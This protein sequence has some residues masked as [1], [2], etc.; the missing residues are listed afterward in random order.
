MSEATTPSD[1]NTV[2][3]WEL[4][5]TDLEEAK[6]FYGSVFGW[7]FQSFGDGFEMAA[8][9]D[10]TPLGGLDSATGKG[11]SPAGR[12]ARIY[13]KVSD[14]EQTLK[15]VASNGGAVEQSRTLISPEYGWWALFSDPSG[16]KI[17]LT[18]ANPA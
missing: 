10:G 2:T 18:T 15:A 5:V 8:A 16:L 17:G 3:W 6:R 9:P 14:L 13:V 4:Q 12:G 7:S 11:E 1:D